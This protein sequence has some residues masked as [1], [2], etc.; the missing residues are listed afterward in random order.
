[1]K[2]ATH[3]DTLGF[4]LRTSHME[5]KTPYP[6]RSSCCLG[7]QEVCFVSPRFQG[8]TVGREE[9]PEFSLWRYAAILQMTTRDSK[10]MACSVGVGGDF[11]RAAEGELIH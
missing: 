10:L 3:T 11:E 2:T 1:M 7:F 9:S 8:G 6:V 5:I 4:E